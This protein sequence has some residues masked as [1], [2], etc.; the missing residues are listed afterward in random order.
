MKYDFLTDSL[1]LFI[2]KEIFVTFRTNLIIDDSS[3]WS[4]NI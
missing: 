2:D 1:I 3:N 4:D